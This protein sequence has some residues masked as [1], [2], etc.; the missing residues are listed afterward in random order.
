MKKLKTSLIDYQ[1]RKTMDRVEMLEAILD[2]IPY[3]TVF[4]DTDH[5]IRYLNKSARYHYYQ[6][7]GYKEL[8]GTSIFDC[9]RKEPSRDKIRSYTEKL[10]NQS[11]DIFLGVNARNLRVYMNPVRDSEGNLVGYFERF[12]LN[13]QK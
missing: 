3:P 9:H 4:V 8:L 6:E 13:S 10:K 5:I 2:A 11:E 1:E 12:E 7:R